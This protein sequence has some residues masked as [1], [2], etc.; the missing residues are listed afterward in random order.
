[1]LNAARVLVHPHAARKDPESSFH[2]P[3]ST[4]LP[5]TSQLPIFLELL[6]T[7]VTGPDL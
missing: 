7:L 5:C 6:V 3:E 2:G 4:G 1:M